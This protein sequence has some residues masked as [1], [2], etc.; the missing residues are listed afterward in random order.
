MIR[1]MDLSGQWYMVLPTGETATISLPGT[2]DENN[3]GHAD[4]LEGDERTGAGGELRSSGEIL[5]R[6]TRNHTYEGPAYFSR[7]FETD[8]ETLANRRLFLDVERSRMLTMKCNG[9]PVPA[10]VKGTV[11]TPYAFELTELVKPG[12]NDVTLCCDNSYPGWP[13]DAIV[14][15]SAATDETQTNWNGLLGRLQLRLERAD[16]ISALR[17]YPDGDKLNVVIELD[18]AKGFSGSIV[19][20]GE[21]LEQS[22]EIN[23]NVQAGRHEVRADGLKLREDVVHWD[24]GVGALYTLT[25]RGEGLDEYSV[26][27]GVRAFGDMDGRLA[28]NGRPFFLR[29]E[30]NCCE[31]PETGH[32]PMTVAEWKQVL[33]TYSSYGV[34]CMR[35]HSHC[36]PDAAF[37]AADELGMMMQPELSHWNPNTAFEDEESWNYYRL[38]LEMILRAYANHP[39]FVMLTLGN[40]LKCGG[41]GYRCMADLINM[42][43]EFDH[44]RMYAEGSNA[45]YGARGPHPASDF[46]TSSNYMDEMI[47]CTSMNMRGVTNNRRPDTR[48]NFTEAIDHLRGEY[49]KPVFGFEVGQYEVLPDFSE[50]DEFNG[51]TRA[52][53]YD[54]MRRHMIESGFESDWA[55]RVQATGEMSLIGYRAEVEAVMRTPGMSGLSL[56]GIQDFPGQGTALVGMLDSHLKPKQKFGTP[57]RFHAFFTDALPLAFMDSYTYTTAQTLH[58]GIKMANYSRAD[59]SGC[60]TLELKDG[61]ETIARREKKL[62]IYPAGELTEAGAV[63]FPLADIKAPARLDLELSIA[64]RRNKYP[65]WVYADAQPTAPDGITVTASVD[66]AI[67]SLMRGGRVLLTPPSDEAHFPQS[68]KAQFTPDFWSVGTFGSQSGF[69]G[70][71]IEEGHPALN[72]FPTEEHSNWQWWYMCRGRAMLLPKGMKS[73][74]TGLDCAVRMRNMG[75]LTELKV[76]EGRLMLSS[77][78]LS[79]NQAQP[80]V[81]ALMQSILGYMAT[82]AFNPEQSVDAGWLKTIVK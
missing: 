6:L 17:V 3:I 66:E 61:N 8:A 23:V 54:H 80:E 44:T 59:I 68:V 65:I 34:N 81:R 32:M 14:Y 62:R 51:V 79:E 4:V 33:S 82:D 16:F 70:C 46:Y 78:G 38:E 47:R 24:E 30:A 71:M 53:N 48:V 41:K 7:M 5:T 67:E 58:V 21:A 37:A 9:V 13:H 42:A 20:S 25:A 57:E 40:E 10:H 15:S 50:I 1:T 43:R 22:A 45:F 77:L 60:M 49:V 64:G 31:F 27:F 69:M 74:V 75:M 55:K 36:P 76:G 39:S 56:L 35:F 29:G 26:R 72:G 19:I 11:S 63:E 12:E 28:I 52:D 2:L 73:I 18:C